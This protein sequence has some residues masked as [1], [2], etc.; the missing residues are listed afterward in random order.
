[1]VLTMYIALILCTFIITILSLYWAV[2]FRVEAN[3]PAV[4][5]FVVDFDGQAPYSDS[6]ISPVVGPIVKQVALKTIASKESHL[7]YI[8]KDPA[9]F[10]ND[11]FAVRRAVLDEHAY[12]AIIVHANATALLYDAVTNG[13]TSYDPTGAAQ[14]IIVSARDDTSYYDYILP[15]L[16]AF[17][18]EVAAAFGPKW[19]ETLTS[20]S[21][22]TLSDAPAQALNPGISFLQ[23]DLRPFSP[24]T[25][26]PAVSIG[27]IYLIIIAFFAF[28]F[29][30]PLHM[31]FAKHSPS[32]KKPQIIIYRILSSLAVYFFMSLIYS[33]VSLAF[34]IPFSNP[35]ASCNGNNPLE[36]QVNANH[37]SKA[38]F[39]VYW[40][41]NF[42]GMAALG[43]ACENVAMIVGQPWTAFWLIFWVI[44]NVSTGFYSLDLAPGFFAWGYAWPLHNVVAASRTLLFDTHSRLGL[45]FGVLLA[46]VAVDIVVFPLASM[47][48]GW[49]MA[50]EQKKEQED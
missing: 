18:T 32:L 14:M 35:C 42:V 1:M 33:F 29:F 9:E 7:G 37:F 16:S 13:N 17:A 38:T 2:L 12:A 26:T 22:I 45:N 6:S 43:L 25:A 44:S 49:K 15:S 10:N 28:S 39:V 23:I 19:I 4:H 41:L 48:M 30:M 20:D 3:L 11:P 24:A 31:Q 50:K 46:W 40:T 47:V 21:S 5:V 36:V 27:L 34:Q 8:I